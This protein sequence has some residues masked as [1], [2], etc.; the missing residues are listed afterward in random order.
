MPHMDTAGV[1][2]TKIVR[3]ATLLVNLPSTPRAVVRVATCES[4]ATR[5]VISF[6][7]LR[8]GVALRATGRTARSLRKGAGVARDLRARVRAMTLERGA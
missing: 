3:T 5:A 6:A 7:H 1:D 8:Q 2:L 4:H